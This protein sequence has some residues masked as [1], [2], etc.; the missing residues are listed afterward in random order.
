MLHK[1]GHFFF[2]DESLEVLPGLIRL[3]GL[4]LGPGAIPKDANSEREQILHQAALI[5]EFNIHRAITEAANAAIH[6]VQVMPLDR[7]HGIFKGAKFDIGIHGL[8][9]DPLHDDVH[10]FVTVIENLGV[11]PK[12]GNDFRALGIKRDL[13]VWVVSTNSIDER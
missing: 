7:F 1:H 3:L 6:D 2:R 13:G 12:E 10:R 4:E 5:G 8:A 9:S 11:A